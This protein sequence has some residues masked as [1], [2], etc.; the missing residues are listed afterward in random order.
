MFSVLKF[1]QPM[2]VVTR[3]PVEKSILGKSCDELNNEDVF[4]SFHAVTLPRSEQCVIL[5]NIRQ[6]LRPCEGKENCKF[7]WW[8]ITSG[9]RRISSCDCTSEETKITVD[10]ILERNAKGISSN[11]VRGEE[12]EFFFFQQLKAQL[13]RMLT[14]SRLLISDYFVA[15]MAKQNDRI[16]AITPGAHQYGFLAV[17]AAL[18]SNSGEIYVHGKPPFIAQHQCLSAGNNAIL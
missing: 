13:T 2:R 10:R 18:M 12:N 5:R 17:K 8:K 1:L 6:I 14:P 3:E 4:K 7:L 11:P 9:S 16:E 15:R